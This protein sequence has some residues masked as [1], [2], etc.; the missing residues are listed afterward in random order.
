VRSPAERGGLPSRSAP[1]ARLGAD[2]EA[3]EADPSLLGEAAFA[4]R[5]RALDRLEHLLDAV[6]ALLDAGE[7]PRELLP[8]RERAEGARRRLETLDER[9]FRRL[10][11]EIRA[12]APLRSLLGR[13]AP[14]ASRAPDEA[15]FDALDAFVDGLLLPLD[16][17]AGSAALE[18]EMVPLHRTPA[19]V[20]LELAERARFREGDV[21]CDLGSGLGQ[22]CLLVS[23]LGGVEAR[24]VEIE[25]AY[26]DYAAARAE[27][28]G[29]RRVEFVAADAREADLS[30]GTVFFLYTPFRGALLAAVLG[31]LRAEARARPIR[32]FTYGPCTASVAREGWLRPE[33]GGETHPYRLAGFRS[34]PPVE[35]ASPGSS[36]G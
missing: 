35:S 36:R 27:E 5:S 7:P 17:P 29:L 28:L 12:G 32:L 34:L 23:L 3:L 16:S 30:R 26:R 8:L 6:E 21:F 22:V 11:A 14:P 25:P 1:A 19:R 33:A 4:A 20:V 31:R 13:Y 9:L 2:L 24:G 18:A 10:R 15:G